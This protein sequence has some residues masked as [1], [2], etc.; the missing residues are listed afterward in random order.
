MMYECRELALR[1]Y[2]DSVPTKS[3]F[4]TPLQICGKYQAH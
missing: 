3:V 2:K 1:T 4:N